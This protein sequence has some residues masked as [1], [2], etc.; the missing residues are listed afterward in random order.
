M[1]KYIFLFFVLILLVGGG[2]WQYVHSH[3]LSSGSVDSTQT[4][5]L[6]AQNEA[7][8]KLLE[9]R[10]N[11]RTAAS[12]STTPFDTEGKVRVLLIGLDKRVGQTVGH[13]DVIQ[14]I[15]IDQTKQDVTI[16]ALPRGTYSPL[17]PGK[18]ATSTDYYVSNACGLGG[19][20]Y[21]IKQIEKILGQ[22][23]D[24]IVVVGFSETLG[25]LRSL[26]LPTT[27]T[28][29]WLRRRQAY[30]IGEPQR[31]RNHS[32]FIKQ[33]MTKYI[34]KDKSIFD[35][36]FRHIIYR[37][38]QTDLSFAQAGII[39]DALGAMDLEANPDRIHLAMKPAHS[40][41]DIPYDPEH[42]DVK[43]TES[44]EEVQK[45]LLTTIEQKKDNK[46]FVSWAFDN[47]IW[48]QIEDE[49]KRESIHYDFLERILKEMGE[50]EKRQEFITDYILEM[51]YTGQNEW[52]KK[53]KSFLEN[54][55]GVESAPLANV[56][57]S[58][59]Q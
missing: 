22:K 7:V 55:L 39:A 40:V 43:A 10:Q 6:K 48:L 5:I 29:Q 47:D 36:A 37:R 12:T 3:S 2:V 51:Q 8:E 14:L 54:E 45:K 21:G 46:E 1:K 4:V 58:P 11:T 33:L 52:V 27:E 42:L 44:K 13:C 15:S 34:P 9:A 26:K 20:E 38:V 30:A 23:T 41:Q 19:L 17:P 50:K 56:S 24:Y 18:G 25:I 32:T 28:L 16:T 31:A 53:G 59:A 35:T 49:Q 57:L